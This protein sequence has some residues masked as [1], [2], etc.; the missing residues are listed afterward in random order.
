MKL[1]KFLLTSSILATALCFTAC[2][3]D[4]N[5]AAANPM[6]APA[7]SEMNDDQSNTTPPPAEPEM[8]IAE[9]AVSN[10]NYSSLVAALTRAGLVEAVSNTD[11]NL[12]VFAPDNAAFDRFLNG[13]ALED[14]PVETLRQVL[15]NHVIGTELKA[16][17]V[18]GSAPGYTKNL[19]EGPADLAGNTTNLSTFYS[20]A[21][22]TVTING[23][24]EV[25]AADA[26]DASNGIIHAVADVIAL[27]KI[28]TFAV[29]DDRVSTLESALISQDLVGTVD[30]LGTATVF[31]PTDTAF[32]KLEAVPTGED[33]TNVLTYH[34]IADVNVVSTDVPALVGNETPAT[35]QGQKLT[36]D[37]NASIKGNTNMESSV[38]VLND[39]QATNGVIH[40]IDSV[41]LPNNEM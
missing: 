38:F 4:D 18:I 17:D 7:A 2:D 19:A 41:L 32:G 31:A 40:V 8:T 5:N 6:P 26:F 12:T 20:V 1:T 39:I 3:D 24:V 15:L 9:F 28:S 33:L 27:P 13:T 37:S 14:V 35:V 30:G 34:V 16:A 25:V 10:E 22:D 36:V 23:T 29:A 21:D 11:A